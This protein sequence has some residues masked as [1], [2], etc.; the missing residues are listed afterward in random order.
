[1]SRPGGNPNIW[2]HGFKTERDESLTAQFTLKVSPSMLEKLKKKKNWRELV[3]QAIAKELQALEEEA[4][5]S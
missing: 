4:Q 5:A 3:R 2:K 1:M